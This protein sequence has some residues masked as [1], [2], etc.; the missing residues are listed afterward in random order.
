[1]RS[2]I[3][4]HI[5]VRTGARCTHIEACA[6]GYRLHWNSD[7]REQRAR[8]RFIVGADGAHSL[9]RRSFFSRIPH[10]LLAIQQWF[11][12]SRS[13]PFYTCIFDPEIT[14]CYAWGLTKG[15][16]F[17]LG[18]AFA[19]G[20]AAAG[21]KRLRKRAEECGFTLGK[22]LKTESCMVLSPRGP[23]DFCCGGN[24]V[25]LLGE[26]AGFISPSSLEGISFAF[27]S[28]RI[29]GEILNS[30]TACP[31]AAYL[32]GTRGLRRKILL[33]I[34][35][36]S[37]LYTPLLRGLIMRSGVQSINV[38]FPLSSEF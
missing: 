12:V 32:A 38:A 6:G 23:Q 22:V 16:C 19:R 36:A 24:G 13:T 2:L 11:D 27:D 5:A 14:D 18:G 33:K 25:F 34:L 30:G 17:I 15:S 7:G 26:A 9:V 8:A 29:L 35:K 28:A 31:Q 21:F 37:C 20:Q 3:P 4:P 10:S 1:L